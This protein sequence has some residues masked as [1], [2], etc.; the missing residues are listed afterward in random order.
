TPFMTDY[1]GVG[2]LSE[3]EGNYGQVI[4]EGVFGALGTRSLLYPFT[5]SADW[6][7]PGGAAALG[8][9][10]TNDRGA[11]LTKEAGYKTSF[12]VFPFEAIYGAANRRN[13][14]DAFISWC[15]LEQPVHGVTLSA[16]QGE[17]SPAGTAVAYEISITNTGNVA[18]LFNL[19]LTGNV[20]ASELSVPNISLNAGET[21]TFTVVVTIPADAGEGATDSVTVTASSV[22][23]GA[24]TA[25]TTLATTVA[26]ASLNIF[27]PIVIR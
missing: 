14:M 12:W 10:G 4:G 23:D 7:T 16:D 15:G 3:G 13:A 27:L 19:S 20:W 17:S 24:V 9:V 26:P 18:D 2:T 6:I 21:A 1:L 11:A 25:T 22:S 8:W 5:D